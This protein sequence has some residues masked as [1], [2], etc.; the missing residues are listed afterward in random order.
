MLRETLN[1]KRKSLNPESGERKTE[2]ASERGERER[3][4]HGHEADIYEHAK[5]TSKWKQACFLRSFSVYLS[6]TPSVCKFL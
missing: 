4:R 2:R 5:S 1:L 6:V 3:E